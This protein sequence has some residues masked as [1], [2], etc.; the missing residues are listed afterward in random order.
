ME[1]ESAERRAAKGW[2]RQSYRHPDWTQPMEKGS[3]VHGLVTEV[4]AKR[5]VV[6]MGV[7]GRLC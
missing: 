3:Y 2:I 6:K 5:V 1:G 4:S 7:A